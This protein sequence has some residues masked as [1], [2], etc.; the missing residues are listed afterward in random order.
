MPY[1]V[2]VIALAMR[3]VETTEVQVGALFRSSGLRL[4]TAQMAWPLLPSRL[5][6]SPDC[7]RKAPMTAVWIFRASARVAFGGITRATRAM[8]LLTK[9][10]TISCTVSHRRRS[11]RICVSSSSMSLPRASSHPSTKTWRSSGLCGPPPSLEPGGGVGLLSLLSLGPRL[12]SR[13]GG[14]GETLRDLALTSVSSLMSLE[15]VCLCR[16]TLSL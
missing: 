8:L 13:H 7:S 9:G 1:F 15:S 2:T 6:V 10:T 16:V 5:D 3:K 4:A 14:A 11:L 12:R